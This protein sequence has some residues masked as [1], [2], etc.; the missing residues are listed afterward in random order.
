MNIQLTGEVRDA[1]RQ[2]P[3]EPLYIHDE[4]SQKDYVIVERD[5]IPWDALN[6]LRDA[7]EVGLRDFEEGRVSS[8][9]PEEIMRLA[10]ERH[11]RRA[12]GD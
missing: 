9:D 12:N 6:W 7:V 10:Q 11:A 2:N 1:L 4:A 3:G 8:W 5:T